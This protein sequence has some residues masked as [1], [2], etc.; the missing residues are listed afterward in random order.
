MEGEGIYQAHKAVAGTICSSF[1][2]TQ[3][4]IPSKMCSAT[5]SAASSAAQIISTSEQEKREE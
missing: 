2:F 5:F 3:A 4:P 1:T